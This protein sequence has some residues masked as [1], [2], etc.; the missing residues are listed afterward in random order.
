MESLEGN[1]PETSSSAYTL[2]KLQRIAALA[3]NAPDMVM[4]SLSYHIDLDFLKEA[5]QRIRKSGA[6]GVDGQTAAEYERNLEENLDSLLNRAKSGAYRAPPV[7]RVRIPKG[8]GK[9]TRPIGIPTVEDKILQKAVSMVLGAVY[10]QDFLDCSYGFRPR[11][12]AHQALDALWKGIMDMHG[13]WVVEVDVRG[14]L[15]HASW[16]TSNNSVGRSHRLADVGSSRWSRADRGTGTCL[17][18]RHDRLP[19]RRG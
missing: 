11:R 14:F 12:S 3:Q 17:S 5:Y 19:R 9:E 13:G 6:T 18:R 2:T 7:R 10:E 1:V 8:E 15:D 4:T 16:C